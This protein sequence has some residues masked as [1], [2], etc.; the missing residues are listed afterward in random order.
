MGQKESCITKEGKE[1]VNV[2]LKKD[3]S[4]NSKDVGLPFVILELKKKQPNTHDILTYSQKSE[5]I[6]T[7][8]PFCQFLFLILGDI[9]PGTYRHGINFNEIISLKDMTDRQEINRLKDLLQKHFLISIEN[10]RRLTET[11]NKRRE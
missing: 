9:S 2:I 4:Q 8:F 7:I 6:K 3:S 1:I 5:M 10:L 11:N